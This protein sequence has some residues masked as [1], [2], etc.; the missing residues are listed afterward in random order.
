M[1]PSKGLVG[2][3]LWAL[4]DQIGQSPQRRTTLKLRCKTLV[5]GV[6]PSKCSGSVRLTAKIHSKRQTIGSAKFSFARTATK[7]LRVRLSAL[8]R[9]SIKSPKSA[10]VTAFVPSTGASRRTATKSVTILP[11]LH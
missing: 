10:T 2:L 9:G 1:Q 8:F 6:L 3:P 11:R 7:T 5:A 4:P